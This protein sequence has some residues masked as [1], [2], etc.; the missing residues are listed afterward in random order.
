[1]N[2]IAHIDEERTQSIK[3]HLEHVAQQAADF[4][5]DYRVAG[6]D[7]SKYA[8]E[9]GLAHD[10]GKY[11]DKFQKKIRENL[12]ISVDHSTAGAK[13]MLKCRMAA[14]TFAI[15]GHHGGIPNGW[16]LTGQNLEERLTKRET[17][18]YADFLNEIALEKVCEP[19]LDA[20]E[21]AFYTRMIFSAL[22]DADFLDTERF[23]RQNQVNR[24]EYEGIDKLYQ[25]L[26]EYIKPWRNITE[27]T[28]EIN[29]IRTGI[30]EQCLKE[31]RGSRGLYRLTVPTGGGKTVSSLAF[32]LQHAKENGLKRVIYVVPYTSIIEQTVDV[33]RNILGEENV[34][35]HYAGSILESGNDEKE[36]YARHRLSIENWDAP[37]IVTTSVQFFESLYSNKVSKCRKLHNM[38]NSVMIFDEAQMIPLAY[39]KPCLK[40]IQTL[41]Q[42]YGVSA[43]LCTA[44]Q[45]ELEKFMEPLAAKE[46][47][48]RYRELFHCMKRTQIRDAG[49][50]SE[51]GLI[52]KIV[53]ERQ[54]LVIVN[55][56]KEARELFLKLPEEGKYH[57]STYMRPID[58]KKVLQDIR[59]RLKKGEVC[60]VI[61]TSL[62]EAGVDVDFPTVYREIAGL[63]SVIQAAGRCNREGLRSCEESIVWV[64]RLGKIPRMIEKNVAMT[65]ETLQK[66]GEYHSLDAIRY[67]FHCLH[68]LDMEALDQY[69][70]VEAFKNGVGEVEMPFRKVAEVFRLIDD[71]T[72]MLIIPIEPEADRL[73]GELE[74]KIANKDNFRIILRQAGV[75]AVN[76]Y[77][78][79]YRELLSDNSAYEV[80]DG[81]AV[82]QKLS[83]YNCELG[84]CHERCDGAT[85]V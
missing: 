39:L 27:K 33:F 10:I 29:K 79:E 1:M 37:V 63:D 30:L 60:R 52:Q 38:A 66:C 51:E 56:K 6:V 62:V 35:A 3:D 68:N 26:S 64:F 45:P 24:S 47:C 19:V 41:I 13:E 32:A 50:I 71:H 54:A 14:A 23:M 36:Y 28:P 70:I 82:L 76:L 5:Q 20:Y 72:K 44:T 84:I 2:K 8:Y 31:G 73:V 25:K 74:E 55:T 11:S 69:G 17:E 57:L 4:C 7:A 75:Y 42:S 34:L 53:S 15:A 85:I 61:S 9:V 81:I 80:L 21:E 22:V 78:G 43:V 58:R 12:D 16:D 48:P 46:I 40:S 77:E 59:E 49:V 65:E 67:Y 83:I 18:P